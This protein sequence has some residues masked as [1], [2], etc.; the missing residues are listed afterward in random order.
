MPCL[1]NKF[2]NA[3]EM[4]SPSVSILRTFTTCSDC[5][6]IKVS[7][8][9]TWQ[10]LT[11]GLEHLH[12]SLLRKIINEGKKIPCASNGNHLHQPAVATFASSPYLQ[13]DMEYKNYPWLLSIRIWRDLLNCSR[14]NQYREIV[15]LCKIN[16]STPKTTNLRMNCNFYEAWKF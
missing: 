2:S 3:F 6:S 5:L 10:H 12:P 16:P 13:S 15:Q 8:F 7:F 14:K 4:D 1:F 9:E 11:L